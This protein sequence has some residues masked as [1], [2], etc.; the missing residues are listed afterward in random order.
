MTFSEDV[1]NFLAV[2]VAAQSV[3]ADR[4]DFDEA[5]A[6]LGKTRREILAALE[7]AG[8]VPNEHSP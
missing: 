7:A 1:L 2:I 8:D 3:T 5:A 4:P 6:L